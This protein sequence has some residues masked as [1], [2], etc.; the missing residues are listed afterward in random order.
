MLLH[1]CLNLSRT[2]SIPTFG[3]FC[4]E[5]V[6]IKNIKIS[7]GHI[8]DCPAGGRGALKNVNQTVLCMDDSTYL[9]HSI[10]SH[11]QHSL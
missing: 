4:N 6:K 3:N 5:K 10:D 2:V 11:V 8:S 1:L 9:T 7:E